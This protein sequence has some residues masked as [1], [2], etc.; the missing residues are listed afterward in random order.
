[1]GFYAEP[2]DYL[3]T[4][5]ERLAKITAKD[6]ENAVDKHL[7]PDRLTVVVVSQTLDKDKLKTALKANLTSTATAEELILTP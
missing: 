2:R 7:H 6:V 3:A 5:P 4:Y 1:M